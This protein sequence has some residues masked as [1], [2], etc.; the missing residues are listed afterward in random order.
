V[1][2][3]TGPAPR[4]TEGAAGDLLLVPDARHSLEALDDAVVL[5]TAAGR[6]P[7]R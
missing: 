3:G 6:P 7:H 5:L 1:T 2:D 4:A